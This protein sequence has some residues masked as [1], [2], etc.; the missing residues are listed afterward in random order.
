MGEVCRNFIGTA[1]KFTSSG[2]IRLGLSTEAHAP[3]SVTLHFVV[4]DT[5]MGVPVEKQKLIFA[6]FQQADS[7]I[8]RTFGGTGLGLAISSQLISLMGGRIWV[9]SPW[10]E[11]GEEGAMRQGSAFH[12]TV[13]LGLQS[14]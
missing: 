6:P 1:I 4:A 7:S 9:E 11:P 13:T 14:S 10:R 3:A 12:F 5:G 2:K 8:N